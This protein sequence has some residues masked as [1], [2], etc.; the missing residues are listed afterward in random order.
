M[1][2]LLYFL[3]ALPMLILA[4]CHDENDLPD[5]NVGI[6]YTGATSLDGSLYIVQGDTVTIDSVYVTPVNPNSRALVANV[7][8]FLDQRL[9]SYSPI[10]PFSMGFLTENLPVGKHTLRLDMTVLEVDREPGTYYL[11][12]PLTVVADSTKLPRIAPVTPGSYTDLA[13]HAE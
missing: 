3:I 12:V 13:R 10:A 1:K 5:V 7:T 6:T 8:Y 2:K 4:S 11:L 9:M